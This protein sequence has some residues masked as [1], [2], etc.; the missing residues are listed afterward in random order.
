MGHAILYP[1]PPPLMSH[2][3]APLHFISNSKSWRRHTFIV[4]AVS[5]N[6]GV[7]L[8]HAPHR[9]GGGD[10]WHFRL[11]CTPTF[12]VRIYY[13]NRATKG[14]QVQFFKLDINLIYI[15]ILSLFAYCSY[16]VIF[17]DNRIKEDMLP[18]LTKVCRSPV[19]AIPFP[20]WKVHELKRVAFVSGHL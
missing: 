1:P 15:H 8:S 14:L 19:F 5:W 18:D 20:C 11:C 16:A 10:I 4:A 3:L 6:S 9:L 12:N 7:P 2:C 13:V 17:Y